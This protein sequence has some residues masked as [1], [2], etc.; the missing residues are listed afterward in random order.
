MEKPV[1]ITGWRRAVYDLIDR[2]IIWPLLEAA[3]T[4]NGT[5]KTGQCCSNRHEQNWWTHQYRDGTIVEPRL[6]LVTAGQI[7]SAVRDYAPFAYSPKPGDTVIDVG[8]GTGW[9]TLTFSRQVGE[10]G[11]VVA[12]E[13]HPRTFAC[14][15]E[16]CRRNHLSNVTLINC[17]ITSRKAE[18]RISDGERDNSNSI[19]DATG[20][21]LV[22]GRTLDDVCSS[23]D[24]QRI[25]LLKMNIEGAERPALPGM[26]DMTRRTRNVCIACHDFLAVRDGRENMRTKAAVAEFLTLHGFDTMSRENDKRPHIRDWIY[27]VRRGA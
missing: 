22:K 11:R 3:A 23:L 7:E 16:L 10:A 4:L 20:P 25:D 18:V 17:A 5:L 2:P 26:K 15:R 6:T 12:I 9:E 21:L 24:L 1:K 14:L 8:A 27:G 13:A 19:V